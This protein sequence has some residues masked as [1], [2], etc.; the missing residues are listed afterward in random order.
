MSKRANPTVIG[1]FVL[2]AVVL[3]IIGVLVFG[4]GKFFKDQLIYVLYFEDNLKGLNVGA[5]VTFRGTKIGTVSDI[6]VVIDAQG[7]SIRTPVFMAL[8]EGAV[9]V[10]NTGPNT[11]MPQLNEEKDRLFIQKM[12][13]ERGMRAQLQMQSLVTGQLLVQLDFFPESPI[14]LHTGLQDPYPEFPTIPSSLEQ[15]TQKLEGIPFKDLVHASLRAIQGLDQLV[16]SPAVKGLGAEARVLLKD[17]R[18]LTQGMNRELVPLVS[19]L[20]DTIRDTQ[21]LV[22]NLD[23]QVSTVSSSFGE[24]AESA[25]RS[26]EQ[27]QQMISAIKD[28]AGESSTLPY[29]F[30]RTLKELNA[31]ARAIRTLADYLERHPEALI[32]GKDDQ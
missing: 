6:K 9:H 2:G 18:E 21:D 3:V 25:R 23:S 24:I 27:T 32:H 26:L 31:A 30:S 16:N 28:V 1:A 17:L 15:L 5:P 10:V 29:Q 19:D 14:K 7:Q 4:S 12:I 8:E 11:I 13:D 20:D 22:R